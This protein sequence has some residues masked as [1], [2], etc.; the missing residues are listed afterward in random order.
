MKRSLIQVSLAAAFLYLRI[1]VRPVA[2]LVLPR[3]VVSVL[4]SIVIGAR[5]SERCET[6]NIV[7]FWNFLG[8]LEFF[9]LAIAL[10]V[11][12]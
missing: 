8:R 11:I 9:V 2:V 1:R 7:G 6:P 5:M 10:V 12:G 4:C 3:F